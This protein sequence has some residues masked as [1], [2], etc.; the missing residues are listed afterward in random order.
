MHGKMHFVGD[1][2]DDITQQAV[3][4]YGKDM[5]TDRIKHIGNDF[6]IDRNNRI[7]FL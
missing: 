3:S 1:A 7:A 2:V 5:D 6:V 4:V